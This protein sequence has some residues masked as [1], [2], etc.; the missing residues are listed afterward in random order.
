MG[1][2]YRDKQGIQEGVNQMISQSKEQAH[3]I[4]S[5][6]IVDDLQHLKE[7]AMQ[8]QLLQQRMQFER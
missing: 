4:T 2:K 3:Y 6:D 7:Q 1:Y 8:L 5:G